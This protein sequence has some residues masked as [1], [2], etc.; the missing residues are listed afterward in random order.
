MDI[1]TAIEERILMRDKKIIELT[2]ACKLSDTL[3]QLIYSPRAWGEL[4]FIAEELKKR[5]E[6][7]RKENK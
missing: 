4:K 7:K 2:R 5:K 6:K 1:R 3:K